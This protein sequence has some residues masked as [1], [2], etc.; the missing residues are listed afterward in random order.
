MHAR[1]LAGLVGCLL[2]LGAA[3]QAQRRPTRGQPRPKASPIIPPN[4][5]VFDRFERMSPEQR[6]R[7][8]AKLPPERKKLMEER[9]EKFRKMP[10]EERER[11]QR[12]Y[13][14]FQQL[15]KERQDALR[16]ALHQ[17]NSLPPDRRRLVRL[18]YQTLGAMSEA[19]K[20]ARMNGDEFRNRFT[21]SERDLLA[22]MSEFPPE[23]SSQQ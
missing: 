16:R 19:E 20:R 6:N 9:L 15:P 7:A 13:A 3:E 22:E 1:L 21:Q 23:S 4:L 14:A 17:F 5:S 11:L 12:Q 18:E 2:S 10:P 8:L